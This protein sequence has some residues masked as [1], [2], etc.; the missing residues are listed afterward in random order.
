MEVMPEHKPEDLSVDLMIEYIARGHGFNKHVLGKDPEPSMSGIN[1]FRNSVDNVGREIKGDDLKIETPDD[2]AHYLD[3]MI[4]DRDTI[5]FRNQHGSVTLYNT[6]DNVITHFTPGGKKT[7]DLGSVY[8]YAESAQ[9]YESYITQPGIQ[10]TDQFDNTTSPGSVRTGLETLA[11]DIRSKPQDYMKAVN[12]QH[13][14]FEAKVLA[15][16]DRPGRGWT[17]DEIANAANNIRGHSQRYAEANNLGIDPENY[18]RMEDR[19]D[20]EIHIK[21]IRQQ[22]I[23]SAE[24]AGE[25]MTYTFG[26]DIKLGYNLRDL[27]TK[28][29]DVDAAL[30]YQSMEEGMRNEHHILLNDVG[31]AVAGEHN[32]L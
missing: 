6:S 19:A 29:V 32:E 15:C 2:L 1:C 4:D 16:V 27:H 20:R 7:M 26:H 23:A 14:R 5:G 18:V 10:I 17:Q 22:A 12:I 31:M 11:D 25:E 13:P 9:K 21:V 24:A 28:A 30:R 3:Q 8:R